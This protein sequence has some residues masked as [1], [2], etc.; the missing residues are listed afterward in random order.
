[1]LGVYNETVKLL[2]QYFDIN[3]PKVPF[4]WDQAMQFLFSRKM[5][6]FPDW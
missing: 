1:M 6:L 5:T 3:F 4:K 2:F